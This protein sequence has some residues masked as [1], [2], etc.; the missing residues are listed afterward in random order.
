MGYCTQSDIEAEI[1]LRSLV[2]LSDD[3]DFGA[4]LAA[5]VA[6]SIAKADSIIDTKLKP[7]YGASVPFSPVPEII[8][9]LSIDLAIVNLYRRQATGGSDAGLPKGWHRDEREAKAYEILNDL[10]EGKLDIPEL[11]S[12]VSE[13]P[14]TT[15]PDYGHVFTR[16]HVDEDGEAVED[17]AQSMDTW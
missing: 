2:Q 13:A 3:E 16:S 10:A 8:K 4:P 17:S 14:Q 9:T 15:T 5:A 11:S 12:A 7:R 1:S 6:R